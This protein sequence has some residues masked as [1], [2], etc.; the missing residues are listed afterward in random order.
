M[1]LSKLFI[2]ELFRENGEC[3]L[4]LISLQLEFH[5]YSGY[6]NDQEE[7]KNLQINNP[8]QVHQRLLVRYH[9]KRKSELI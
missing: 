1:A 4:E 8:K 5:F 7:F 6:L 2:N 9:K 3:C